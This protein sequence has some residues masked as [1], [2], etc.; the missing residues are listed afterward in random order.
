MWEVVASHGHRVRDIRHESDARHIVH[1][2]GLTT[3]I[4]PGR[5]VIADNR[6]QRVVAEIHHQAATVPVR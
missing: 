4:A 3:L 2:L 6:G 5:Y 1:S